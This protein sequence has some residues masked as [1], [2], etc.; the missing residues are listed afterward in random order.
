MLVTG[1]PAVLIQGDL[2][3]YQEP[4]TAAM[5]MQDWGTQLT[6]YRQADEDV[7]VQFAQKFYYGE[8]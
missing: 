1:G 8:G 7:L 6:A 4:C 5:L 3:Q 2:N